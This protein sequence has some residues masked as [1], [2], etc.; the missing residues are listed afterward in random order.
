MKKNFNVFLKKLKYNL[1]FVFILN[2]ITF[3]LSIKN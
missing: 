2:K 3:G 1:I